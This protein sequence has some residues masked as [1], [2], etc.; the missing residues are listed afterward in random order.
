MTPEGDWKV[1]GGV[2]KGFFMKGDIQ[3]DFWP[4][5]GGR[6]DEA[7]LRFRMREICL[8]WVLDSRLCDREFSDEQLQ[9]ELDVLTETL[10]NEF[11]QYK[12]YLQSKELAR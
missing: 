10:V 4:T 9:D 7:E 12:Q 6:M 5:R 2:K 3:F 1:P 8:Q 11:V